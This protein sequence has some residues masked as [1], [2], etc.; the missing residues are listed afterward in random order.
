MSILTVTVMVDNVT[1]QNFGMLCTLTQGGFFVVVAVVL[2]M[3]ITGT[4]SNFEIRC[5]VTRGRS[6]IS[7]KLLLNMH[8]VYRIAAKHGCCMVTCLKYAIYRV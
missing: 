8:V 6:R 7:G 5:D 4:L 1:P 3:G 2:N